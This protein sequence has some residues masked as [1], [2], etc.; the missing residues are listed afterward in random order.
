MGAFPW[1]RQDPALTNGRATPGTSPASP[2]P[3]P[4]K[5]SLAVGALLAGAAVARG[6]QGCGS[7]VVFSPAA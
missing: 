2:P 7:W 1:H 3:S 5:V 6:R 4:C